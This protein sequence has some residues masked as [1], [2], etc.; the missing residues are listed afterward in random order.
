MHVQCYLRPGPCGPHGCL[1]NYLLP[2]PPLLVWADTQVP[3]STFRK[4][5][6]LDVAMGLPVKLQPDRDRPLDSV[7]LS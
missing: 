3:I 4:A 6:G 1:P 7:P 5:S 2:R